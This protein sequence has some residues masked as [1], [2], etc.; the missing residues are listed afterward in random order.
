MGDVEAGLVVA[1]GRVIGSG[2]DVVVVASAGIVVGLVGG[3]VGG[4]IG[5]I[6]PCPFDG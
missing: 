6:G 1:T 5:G 3:L 2:G 4:E